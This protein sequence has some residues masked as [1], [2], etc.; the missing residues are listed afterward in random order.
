MLDNAVADLA[1]RAGWK[2]PHRDSDGGYRFRLE[3]DLDFVVFSP[4]S[5]I[6]VMRAELAELPPPGPARDDLLDAVARRQA[7]VCRTRASVAALEKAGQSLLKSVT[8]GDRL[9]VYHTVELAAGQQAF[10][11]AARDF[12]NDLVWWKTACGGNRAEA[13]EVPETRSPFT[14]PGFFPGSRY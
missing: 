1:S 12:L 8:S 14:I 7:G 10:D 9:I 4:D 6:C 3:K 5:R 2:P 11:A 13:A